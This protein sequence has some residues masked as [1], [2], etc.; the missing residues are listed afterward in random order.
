MLRSL[1]P[2]VFR[3][4]NGVKYN[5]TKS[6]RIPKVNFQKAEAL[7]VWSSVSACEVMCREIESRQGTGWWLL[8]KTVY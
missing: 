2:T 4:K 3:E 1:F 6:P 8:R 5:V 7:A